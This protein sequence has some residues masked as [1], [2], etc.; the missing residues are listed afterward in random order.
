M[1]H[2]SESLFILATCLF[3]M[4]WILLASIN[5]DMLFAMVSLTIFALMFFFRIK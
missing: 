3:G 2:E 1:N 5:G 4:L